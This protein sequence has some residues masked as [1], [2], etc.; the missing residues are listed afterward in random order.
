[1]RTISEPVLTEW[2]TVKYNHNIV[3]LS[4]Q[5]STIDQH[6]LRKTHRAVHWLTFSFATREI[7]SLQLHAANPNGNVSA[8][9]RRAP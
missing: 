3:I 2:D 4:L 6:F 9:R 7:E 5:P 8:S 1:M